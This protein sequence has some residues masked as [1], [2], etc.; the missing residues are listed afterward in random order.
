MRHIDPADWSDD[1]S[2]GRLGSLLI[3]A[4]VWL[5]AVLFCLVPFRRK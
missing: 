4:A 1:D 2:P 3:T 5:A